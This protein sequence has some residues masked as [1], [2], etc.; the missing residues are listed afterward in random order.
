MEFLVIDG[1]HLSRVNAPTSRRAALIYAE[2]HLPREQRSKQFSVRVLPMHGATRIECQVTRRGD[3][4]IEAIA[5][6]VA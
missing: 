6:E 5:R 1:G 3:E 4:T 2:R